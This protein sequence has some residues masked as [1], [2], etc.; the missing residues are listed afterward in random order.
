[1]TKRDRTEGLTPREAKW[2]LRNDR[3]WGWTWDDPT[4]TPLTEEEKRKL[5]EIRLKG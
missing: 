1:M 3:E 4:Y 5:R 2:A